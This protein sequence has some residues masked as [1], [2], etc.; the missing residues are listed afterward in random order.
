MT[1]DAAVSEKWT[2][3]VVDDEP[4]ARRRIEAL[5]E[6]DPDVAVVAA[7]GDVDAVGPL[8]AGHA[9][10]LLFM[11]VQMPGVSGIELVR[12][13]PSELLPLVIFVTA[14]DEY[15]I[16]A[17]D[18]H[19]ADY[20]LKPVDADRFCLALQ[21]AKE[22]LRLLHG[23]AS[24]PVRNFLAS[25]ATASTLDRIA[26]QSNQRMRLLRVEEIEWIEAAGNYVRVHA[27]RRHY[28][29]RES[30]GALEG[31]LDPRRFVR[32][33]RST[34]VNIDHIHELVPRAFGDYL[35]YTRG[36]EELVLSRRYRSRVDPLIGRM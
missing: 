8:I 31:R 25:G 20:V 13:I 27:A 36:G 23:K 32:I 12:A 2:A 6:R 22:R 29:L 1:V 30:I 33:H 9:P 28:L 5:L 14:Y 3:I 7:S 11:D 35:V 10:D 16:A 26:V 24:D 21:R 15:A 17:F 34:I 4:P 19:A 18:L